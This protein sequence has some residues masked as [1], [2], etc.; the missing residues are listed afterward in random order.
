MV[1]VCVVGTCSGLQAPNGASAPVCSQGVGDGELYT[2][3][4]V[5]CPTGMAFLRPLPNILDCWEAGVWNTY[6]PYVD[7][8]L[9]P[10]GSRFAS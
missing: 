2:R 1:Y 3:C 4:T 8:Q 7:L 9:P 10:C 6:N 5:S